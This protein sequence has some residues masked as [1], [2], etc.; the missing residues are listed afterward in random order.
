MIGGLARAQT[1]DLPDDAPFVAH[2]VHGVKYPLQSRWSVDVG[3]VKYYGER[4]AQTWGY[5]IQPGYHLSEKLWFAMPIYLYQSSAVGNASYVSGGSALVAFEPKISVGP[6]VGYNPIYGKF[7]LGEH[8]QHFR[9]GFNGGLV[10]MQMNDVFGNSYSGSSNWSFGVQ[11][12]LQLQAQLN[13]AWEIGLF[14]TAN[15]YEL[16]DSLS[17]DAGNFR[18]G[19]LYGLGFGRTF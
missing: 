14:S 6:V 8:I 9:A 10:A 4:L 19:W 2:V 18:V 15:V 13:A 1:E 7:V 12:G 17:G 5:G 16:N 3:V 11:L